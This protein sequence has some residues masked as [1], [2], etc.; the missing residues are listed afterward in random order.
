MLAGDALCATSAHR[1]SPSLV[2]AAPLR[3][4]Q[5]VRSDNGHGHRGCPDELSALSHSGALLSI[6]SFLLV[7]CGH[8]RAGLCHLLRAVHSVPRDLAGDDPRP[9]QL[10]LF[11]DDTHG[12][13]DAD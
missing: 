1:A 11:G 3:E 10:A 6:D 4:M 5:M 8:L 12:F 9:N 7:K 2:R 13:R